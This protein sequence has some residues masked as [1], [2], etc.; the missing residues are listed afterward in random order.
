LF[1]REQ[2]WRLGYDPNLKFVTMNWDY[3]RI[4]MEA[5][6]YTPS[7]HT[8]TLNF[9]LS[10]YPFPEGII[11]ILRSN[12]WTVTGRYCMGH[13]SHATQDIVWGPWD[14]HL[15]AEQKRTELLALTHFEQLDKDIA[16]LDRQI[17]DCQ[18][19]LAIIRIVPSPPNREEK[20]DL[21]SQ[22]LSDFRRRMTELICK[23]SDLF[24]PERG[25]K[26]LHDLID[27]LRH[28]Q[29]TVDISRREQTDFMIFAFLW[30]CECVF[31]IRV[32]KTFLFDIS[33]EDESIFEMVRPKEPFLGQIREL[34]TTDKDFKAQWI[35]I[36]STIWKS[37]QYMDFEPEVE[38]RHSDEFIDFYPH[39]NYLELINTT[40]V[41]YESQKQKLRAR[42][43]EVLRDLTHLHPDTIHRR[44]P[45]PILTPDHSTPD[46]AGSSTKRKLDEM[47]TLLDRFV[48]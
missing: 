48:I 15:Q 45:S 31:D 19:L 13:K 4:D 18:A 6:E 8:I 38:P 3:D 2:R 22:T 33:P 12:G 16:K 23:H 35:S 41:T 1:S 25:C 10:G 32:P 24:V 29:L 46:G 43:R 47:T 36:I 5:P 27:Y 20:R 7:T 44:S 14:Y 30:C 9:I 17:S 42:R 21:L 28:M 40:V 34:F 11:E 39:H 37:C 26:Y